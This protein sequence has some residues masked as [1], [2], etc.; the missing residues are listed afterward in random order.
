MK[1]EKVSFK[2][3]GSKL[4][5]IKEVPD[6]IPA[7]GVILFHGLTGSKEDSPLINESSKAL[8]ENGFITFRFDFYGSGES[9]GKMQDKTM[10]VLEQNAKDAVDYFLQDQRVTNLG[11][12]GRSI[13]GTLVC[14]VPPN[15]RIKARVSASGASLAEKET[16]EKLEELKRREQELERGK[17][18]ARS[19][20]RQRK[21]CKI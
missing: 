2:S 20:G 17:K 12:W 19:R 13:G 14:L 6:K 8:V 9:L 10:A 3:A 7:P 1:R 21:V 18:I 5:G 11:L 15:G 4:V 16:R